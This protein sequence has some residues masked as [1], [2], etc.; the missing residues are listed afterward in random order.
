MFEGC[1]ANHGGAVCSGWNAGFGGASSE[2]VPREDAT[3][4]GKSVEP[5]SVGNYGG[6]VGSQAKVGG[7]LEHPHEPPIDFERLYAQMEF[8]DAVKGGHLEREKVI[9]ARR[10]EMD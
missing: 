3:R 6:E 7:E 1:F 8:Y 2:G 10:L 5:T 9:E 4:S